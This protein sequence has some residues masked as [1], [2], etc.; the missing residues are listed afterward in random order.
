MKSGGSGNGPYRPAERPPLKVTLPR[1]DEIIIDPPASGAQ[2]VKDGVA[3]GIAA[4]LNKG[5]RYFGSSG[6][7]L[8]HHA[9][10]PEYES[11]FS[12]K[13]ARVGLRGERSTTSI[14]RAWMKDKPNAV[15]IDSV[16]IRGIGKETVDEETGLVEGG[17]TDHILIIGNQVIL[18]D[19]KRWKSSRTYS[20]SDKGQILRQGRSFAGG[21][22]H[23]KQA[24]FMWKKYLHASAKLSSIVCVNNERVFVKID[25]NWKKQPY[26][27]TT[28]EKLPAD[29]DYRYEKM[30][31]EDRTHINSTL[32]AQV[33]ICCIKPFDPMARVFD[34]NSIGSFK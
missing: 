18:I 33:S 34:M 5:V 32:I 21:R 19:T 8:S 25:E 2:G 30:S 13:V 28:A 24:K 12:A 29:L 14:V 10:N 17:D 27:L 6:A 23:A 15:L 31:E 1:P 3:F 16:H 7:S 4:M 9:L 26:R 20:V 22:V 11:E